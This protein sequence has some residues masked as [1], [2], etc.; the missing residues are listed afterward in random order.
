MRMS[1]GRRVHRQRA[2]SQEPKPSKLG[3]TKLSRV[4]AEH[5]QAALGSE[6][7]IPR[8]QRCLGVRRAASVVHPSRRLDI[9][10]CLSL[11]FGELRKRFGR[12][13]ERVTSDDEVDYV[14]LGI[15]PCNSYDFEND[16]PR[17]SYARDS[18]GSCAQICFI[19]SAS[20]VLFLSSIAACLYYESEYIVVAQEYS[21]RKKELLSGVG[22]AIMMYLACILVSGYFWQRSYRMNLR[23]IFNDHDKD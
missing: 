19:F 11:M 20:G 22:G 14:P 6:P 21:H 18:D 10:Q 17:I 12:G 4:L 13:Y 7:A 23:P 1:E 15:N 9:T 2:K 3:S 8:A 5:K 16:N